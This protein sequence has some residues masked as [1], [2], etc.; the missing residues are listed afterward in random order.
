MPPTRRF[1][2]EEG[3]SPSKSSSNFREGKSIFQE[4]YQ[5]GISAGT[6]K[7]SKIS[8]LVRSVTSQGRNRINKRKGVSQPLFPT[9]F[10]QRGGT[11]KKVEREPRYTTKNVQ[12]L[13]FDTSLPWERHI[14]LE[15]DKSTD[16]QPHCS[17]NPVRRKNVG[18]SGS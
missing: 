7:G 12:S 17:G 1:T 9:K 15:S 3:E 8:I 4:E 2:G 14:F 10:S 6:R 13:K 18:G 5:S 11:R 16:A